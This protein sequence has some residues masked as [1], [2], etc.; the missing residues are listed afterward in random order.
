MKKLIDVL[1]RS[2]R[3]VAVPGD[4]KAFVYH[5]LR[6]RKNDF[7][8]PGEMKPVGPED[9]VKMDAVAR[10]AKPNPVHTPRWSNKK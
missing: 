1:T 2:G 8:I 5:A 6:H 4:D 3:I 10:A 9:G 7:E